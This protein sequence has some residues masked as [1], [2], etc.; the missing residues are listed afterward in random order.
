MALPASQLAYDV[1]TTPIGPITLIASRQGLQEVRLN[2]R[3]PA[4]AR[5]SPGQLAGLR[6]QFKA[7]FAGRRKRFA[8]KL[9]CV[10]GTPFQQQVWQ[11]LQR[12]P[13]GETCSYGELA[14]RIGRPGAA[15]AVGAANR[16]N[17]WA[18]IVPCHRVIGANGD[19]T[20]YGGKKGIPKKRW[21]LNLERGQ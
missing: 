3:V 15:R 17:P 5:R 10:H 19:L 2:G 20:G 9:D 11:E 21:L 1:V 18:I 6:R 7:Y 4:A 8:C 12:I 14:R 16:A 13:Y